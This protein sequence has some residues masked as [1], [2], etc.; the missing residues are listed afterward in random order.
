[1]NFEQIKAILWLRWRLTVNQFSRGGA[2]NTAVGIGLVALLVM[3]ALASGAGAFMAGLLV[4]G[5]APPLALLATWDG[6]LAVFLFI[7]GVALM[8][9]IQRSESIDIGKL[10]HLP[11]TPAQVFGFNYAASHLTPTLILFLPGMLGLC[12]GLVLSSGPFF[13]LLTAVVLSFV[14]MLTSWTYCLRG[15]LAS[16]MVDK[17]RRRAVVVWITIVFVVVAQLPNLFFNSSWFRHNTRSSTTFR[18]SRGE[19]PEAILKMHLVV[20]A[21]WPAYS[22]VALKSGNALPALG[23]TAVAGLMGLLGVMRGYRLTIRFYR[24][25]EAGASRKRVRKRREDNSGSELLVEKRLPW[26]KDDTAALALATL[27]SLLRA[28]ELKMAFIT[29]LVFGIIFGSLAFG[30]AKAMPPAFVGVLAGTAAAVLAAFSFAPTMSN[31]FGLDRNGFRALVLLP[32]ARHE[33]LFAK[34]LAFFPFILGT[35]AAM[36]LLGGIVLHLSPANVLTGLFQVPT[37]FM[38][39]CLVCNMTAILAPYRFSPGTLQAKKQKPIVILAN[40]AVFLTM[41][42]VALPLAVAPLAQLLFSYLGWADWVAVSVPA[43]VVVLAV[44]AV[45]YWAL[46]PLQGRLLQRRELAILK[47]VTEENE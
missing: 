20:P 9:E 29:P 19:V 27:R 32:T 3:G 17:R 38:L 47:E 13:I 22:A 39:F 26:I 34:N 43:A 45:L 23:A 36:L 4:F 2:I 10:L 18:A 24:G 7:W 37:A 12:A 46:L 44:V 31:T 5:K 14:F 6:I 16:L 41:P 8:V 28:P 40:L 21:G 25:V 1:M 35:G 11:I 30:R 33:M 42:I 15:W